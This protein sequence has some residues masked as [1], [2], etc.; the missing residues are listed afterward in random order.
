M[1]ALVV[2]VD[3]AVLVHSPGELTD[4]VGK[5]AKACL[6]VAQRLLGLDLFGN[7]RVGAEPADDL[8]GFIANGQGA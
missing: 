8:A 6:A 3:P 1:P 2:P 5:L 7:V 4:N